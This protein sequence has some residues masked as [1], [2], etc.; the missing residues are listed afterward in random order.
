MK[1]LFQAAA[2]VGRETSRDGL[3]PCT[4]PNLAVPQGPQGGSTSVGV[5]ELPWLLEEDGLSTASTGS[6]W[7]SRVTKGQSRAAAGQ[8]KLLPALYV[9]LLEGP[10]KA[11]GSAAVSSGHCWPRHLPI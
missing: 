4:W 1:T 3:L 11:H 9:T 2:S 5:E 7:A 6:S 10:A 8:K